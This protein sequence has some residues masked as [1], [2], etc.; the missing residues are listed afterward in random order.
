M[1]LFIVK[2]FK[3]LIKLLRRKRIYVDIT[4]INDDA[5]TRINACVTVSLLFVNILL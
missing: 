3:S 1:C 4:G 2:K 5:L